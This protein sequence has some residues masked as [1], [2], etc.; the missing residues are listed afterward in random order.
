M[1][2]VIEIKGELKDKGSTANKLG[3]MAAQQGVSL[4]KYITELFCEH[5][6]TK[7]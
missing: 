3:V 5:V 2:K 7:K 6:K 1:K 4:S